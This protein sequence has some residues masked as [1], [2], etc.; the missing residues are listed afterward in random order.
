MSEVAVGRVQAD[1]GYIVWEW[2]RGFFL[3][4]LLTL[5]LC[6]AIYIVQHGEFHL[7]IDETKLAELGLDYN[8][9]I[10]SSPKTW[11]IPFTGSPIR[12]NDIDPGKQDI[13]GPRPLALMVTGQFPNAYENTAPPQWLGQSDTM[14]AVSEPESIAEAPGKLILF[15]SGEMF[16][17]RILGA[18]GN[19][20]LMLNSV[21]ALVLG[22]DLINVRTKMLTQRFISET[23]AAS[24]MFWRF[25]VTILVPLILI[26]IGI[27]R[28]MMR[29][30]R[31]ETFQ[32]LLEQ[33]AR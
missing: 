30:Q 10:E 33:S 14:A 11:M 5:F 16:S 32:R 23:S 27:A 9:L 13:I 28:F 24:K 25:F 20:L 15:G 29:R 26:A 21:D 4:Y 3:R 31:R 6:L 22:D 17:D 2:F 18:A 7:D 19:A 1:Y 12:P 8:L